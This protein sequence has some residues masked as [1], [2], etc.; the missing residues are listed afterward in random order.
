MLQISIKVQ[1]EATCNLNLLPFLSFRAARITLLIISTCTVGWIPAVVNF[2]LVCPS[3]CKYK[4]S[5]LSA[6][7]LFAMHAVGYVLVILKSLANPLIFALRQ[8]H[9][10]AALQGRRGAKWL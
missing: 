8:T 10:K 5:D 3:D 7:T 4:P 2:L 1:L 9:I 6:E